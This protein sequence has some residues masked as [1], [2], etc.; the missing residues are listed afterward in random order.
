M[1][2]GSRDGFRVLAESGRRSRLGQ[3]FHET[4]VFYT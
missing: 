3:P 4:P 1:A 2:R